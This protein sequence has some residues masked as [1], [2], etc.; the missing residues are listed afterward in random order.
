MSTTDGATLFM[1]L[2]NTLATVPEF[3]GIR[4]AF[5]TFIFN[6]E[7]AD[8]LLLENCDKKLFVLGVITKLSG[9]A[10]DSVD[11]FTFDDVK[12]LT[13][14]LKKHF[15]NGRDFKSYHQDLSRAAMLPDESHSQYAARIQNLV[16]G[17]KAALAGT[18]KKGHTNILLEA[19]DPK[20]C[21][22]DALPIEIEARVSARKP[23]TLEDAIDY[24]R[25]E[26]RRARHRFRTRETAVRYSRRDVS[27]GREDYQ[28]KPYFERQDRSRYLNRDAERFY[29]DS[30][31][32]YNNPTGFD[33]YRR[34]PS[35]SHSQYRPTNSESGYRDP[36]RRDCD[37]RDNQEVHPVRLLERDHPYHPASKSPTRENQTIRP[38]NVTWRESPKFN[39]NQAPFCA[40][41]NDVG[42]QTSYCRNPA[43]PKRAQS[44]SIRSP[45]PSNSNASGYLN[46]QSARRS[47]Q[48][49][50]APV[51]LAR[52]AVD[53]MQSDVKTAIPAVP[54]SKLRLGN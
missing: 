20:G 6:V 46:S 8:N 22:L 35:P 31:K 47:N 53:V 25:E 36:Y 3:D 41:C 32:R 9:A 52:V 30:Y 44:P 34:S 4:P 39:S 16:R 23:N 43:N 26:D 5:R 1:Y 18:D 2:Q 11:G 49:A 12:N 24:A 17:A 38:K 51:K 10:N 40:F 37:F 33:R 14:H 21:F 29:P 19:I 45:S 13:K 50:S 7:N 42:H 54:L 27:P 48:M 28:E 15:S